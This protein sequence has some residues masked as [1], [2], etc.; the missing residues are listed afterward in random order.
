MRA[1]NFGAGPCT[2]PVEVLEEVQAEFLDFGGSGMSVVELSHRSSEYEQ[3]HNNAMRLMRSVSGAPDDFAILFIQ[4]GATLQ[5]GMIPMNLVGP[6]QKA[7]HVVTGSWAKAA[8]ADAKA[9]TSAYS[10]WDGADSGYTTMPATEE[11][12]IEPDTRYLHLTTN[13]TIGGIRMVEFPRVEVPLVADVSSEFLARPIDWSAHDVVYGG[14]QKNLGPSGMSVVFIRKSLVDA[15]PSTLPK[16]LR[17]DWH[18]AADSLANTPA[19]FPTYV[20][21]KVLTQIERSGGVEALERRSAAKAALLYDVIDGSEGFYSNPVDAAARSHMN[22]VFRLPN[23]ELEREFLAEAARRH[24]VGLKGHRSVGGCRASLYAALELSS[25]E[26][27]SEL[28]LGFAADH[29]GA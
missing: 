13:E 16:Y 3:V 27:L 14:I 15:G 28:M 2:L 4:G 25:V 11:L 18:A 6:D 23:E 24:M 26:A 7:G 9:V 10:A 12:V 17:F 29:R 8:L 22:V 5:F 1:H 20:M 21:A 19:M